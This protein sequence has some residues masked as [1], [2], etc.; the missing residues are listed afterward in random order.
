MAESQDQFPEEFADYSCSSPSYVSAFALPSEPGENNSANVHRHGY[1]NRDKLKSGRSGLKM[2]SSSVHQPTVF[3][4]GQLMSNASS[5]LDDDFREVKYTVP[6]AQRIRNTY[7]DSVFGTSTHILPVETSGKAP[8]Q[9]T[10]TSERFHSDLPSVS[11]T[12]QRHVPSATSAADNDGFRIFN[13]F[14]DS[15]PMKQRPKFSHGEASLLNVGRKNKP[16]K[17]KNKLSKEYP[18]NT[19]SSAASASQ[20]AP[21]AGGISNKSGVQADVTADLFTDLYYSESETRG[22]GT[23]AASSGT[24][25][26]AT[27][28]FSV[29]RVESSVD[30]KTKQKRL[31]PKRKR[32]ADSCLDQTFAVLDSRNKMV[33]SANH[34][35]H[36]AMPVLADSTSTDAVERPKAISRRRLRRDK[37]ANTRTPSCDAAVTLSDINT[38][39]PNV[40]DDGANVTGSRLR[41]YERKEDIQGKTAT[42]VGNLSEVIGNAPAASSVSN[43]T[44][45]L[46]NFKRPRLCHPTLCSAGEDGNSSDFCEAGIQRN[47]T[48]SHSKKADSAFGQP[49]ETRNNDLLDSGTGYHLGAVIDNSSA[50]SA[51]ADHVN[52]Q[53]ASGSY[54]AVRK[55][56]YGSQSRSSGDVHPQKLSTTAT[57]GIDGRLKRRKYQSRR[58]CSSDEEDGA[59]RMASIH[60][61]NIGA[62]RNPISVLPEVRV[63]D[64][65]AT[66]LTSVSEEAAS[67][68]HSSEHSSN[69][70]ATSRTSNVE[71]ASATN[72]DGEAWRTP[73]RRV[74]RT[75]RMSCPSG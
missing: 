7:E 40:D 14:V 41:D 29:T 68:E 17:T 11:V 35:Q 57:A 39:I 46:S 49:E 47:S 38:C 53:D 67:A 45:I 1:R 8:S 54:C 31:Q 62:S 37:Y 4:N 66:G 19:L 36:F 60:D 20:N 27:R 74:S 25:V 71:S 69:L 65:M 28:S 59:S 12:Q 26:K 51:I 72:T 56:R 33:S 13:N 64:I 44:S 63:A 2:E 55:S 16:G 15:P 52:S 5:D 24:K 75:A 50:L 34:S 23:G 73:R 22:G 43:R 32:V 21:I 6:L 3:A 61:D 18:S 42:I 48:K 9:S 10:V 70:F 58:I 30:R